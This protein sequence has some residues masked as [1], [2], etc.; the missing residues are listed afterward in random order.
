MKLKYLVIVLACSLTPL[1][2]YAGEQLTGDQIREIFSDKTCDI[3]KADTSNKKKKY[4]SAYTAADGSRILYIPWKDKKS[5]RKWWVDNG[6]YCGSHPTKGDY[7]RDI[8]DVGD[9]FLVTIEIAMDR[10]A[11]GPYFEV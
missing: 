8:I 10:S 6:R 7:C 11:L 3:E 9:G 1:S 4:L 5:E 2:S